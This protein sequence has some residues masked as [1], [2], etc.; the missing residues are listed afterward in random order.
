MDSL[1]IPAS[2]SDGEYIDCQYLNVPLLPGKK[3][4]IELLPGALANRAVA[5]N[6]TMR[7]K[8][9][10][11]LTRQKNSGPS[12]FQSPICQIPKNAFSH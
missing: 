11:I 8:I 3:Y 6:D 10:L 1:V 5:E 12:I 2:I 4:S 9:C 7:F